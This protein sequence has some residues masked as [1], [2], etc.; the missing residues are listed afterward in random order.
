[1]SAS[2]IG[3]GTEHLDNAPYEQVKETIDAALS[4]GIN[5]MDVFMPGMPY[6]KI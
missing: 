4:Q 3:L 6:V 1:M 2:V 5:I